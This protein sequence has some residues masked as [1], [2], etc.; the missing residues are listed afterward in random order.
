MGAANA[1]AERYHFAFGEDIVER[2]RKVG[3]GRAVG[4]DQLLHALSARR[5]G[6]RARVLE[7]VGSHELV[8]GGHVALAPRLLEEFAY[9]YFGVLFGRHGTSSFT[10]CPP[11]YSPTGRHHGT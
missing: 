7:V 2:H 6:G 1:P 3:E 10:N 8:H 5:Q 9:E 4:S 11:A